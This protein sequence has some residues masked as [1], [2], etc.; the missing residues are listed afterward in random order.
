MVDTNA[1][2]RKI[3]GKVP[4][5]RESWFDRKEAEYEEEKAN[6][7]DQDCSYGERCESRAA[8][9]QRVIHLMHCHRALASSAPT[10]LIARKHVDIR[11]L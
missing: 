4:N 6:K 3:H 10:P 9:R 8:Q 7:L 5:P 2:R 11:I 1:I